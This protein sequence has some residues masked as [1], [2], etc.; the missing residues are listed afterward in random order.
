MMQINFNYSKGA[1]AVLIRRM[2]VVQTDTALI[3]EPRMCRERIIGSV[4]CGSIY[5]GPRDKAARTC[6]VPGTSPL[7]LDMFIASAY[8][9]SNARI[10]NDLALPGE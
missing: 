7:L 2:A 9:P 1:T 5:E 6:I 3:Q 4:G 10:P 8:F